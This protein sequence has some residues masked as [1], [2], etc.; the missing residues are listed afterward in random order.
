MIRY[1]LLLSYG[2]DMFSKE[3]VLRIAV[4]M[5]D[6]LTRAGLGPDDLAAHG[7]TGDEA[8]DRYRADWTRQAEQVAA[9]YGYRVEVVHTTH[10]N[11]S[12]EFAELNTRTYEPGTDPTQELPVEGRVWQ[13]THDRMALGS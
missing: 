12:P 5:D 8:M 11:D 9:D 1:S 13:A 2:C 10:D 4:N 6:D 3:R 7:Y